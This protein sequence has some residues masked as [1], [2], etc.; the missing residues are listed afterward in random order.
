MK[1][2]AAIALGLLALSGTAQAETLPIGGVYPGGTDEAAALQSIVVT[3]FGGVDGPALGYRIEDALRDVYIFRRPWFAMVPAGG[4]AE[5]DAVLRGTAG[6]DVTYADITLKRRR[7]VKR[8]ADG[9]C[10]EHDDVEVDCLRRR[11]ALAWS[12]RLVRREG[13]L[14]FRGDGAPEQQLDYCPEDDGEVK[15]TEKAVAELI[16]QVADG[17]RY[18]L[19]PYERWQDVRILESRKG[20]KGE[21]GKAVKAAV[22]LTKTDG[23]AA[24]AAWDA[25]AADLPDH[26]T[27]VFN[28]GLC[29][30]MLGQLDLAET[31]YR[32]VLE[33][34]PRED[35]AI[36]GLR[37]IDAR[38]RA[39]RQIAAHWGE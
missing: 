23:N 9:K 7:C 36:T 11:V 16:A 28:R 39:D 35:Y 14:V 8:D 6:A 4:G 25:L 10:T 26:P 15:S 37:R 33:L 19:A 1:L 30:E 2:F 17:V 13:E 21:V 34:A 32:R 12:V 38:R 22:T 31:H 24:C 20:L 29:A 5:A 3:D 27:V 18:D